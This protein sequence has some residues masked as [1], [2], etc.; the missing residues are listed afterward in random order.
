MNLSMVA[1]GVFFSTVNPGHTFPITH[2]CHTTDTIIISRET[3]T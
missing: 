3:N 1:G 2:L